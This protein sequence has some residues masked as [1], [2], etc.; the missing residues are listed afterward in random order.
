MKDL[1]SNGGKQLVKA[2]KKL[3]E[4]LVVILSARRAGACIAIRGEFILEPFEASKVGRDGGRDLG[5][6]GKV[7]INLENTGGVA[8]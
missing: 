1:V 6:S 7:T 2:H 4:L 3:H 5:N 8:L